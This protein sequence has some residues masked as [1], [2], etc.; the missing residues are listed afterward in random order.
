MNARDK[1]D[2][3]FIAIIHKEQLKAWKRASLRIFKLS[4]EDMTK[5]EIISKI[6]SEEYGKNII[7]MSDAMYSAGRL[8]YEAEVRK[9]QGLVRKETPDFKYNFKATDKEALDI[10]DRG[11]SLFISRYYDKQL[12]PQ[13]KDK[14]AELI[15]GQT[16]L[17]EVKESMAELLGWTGRKGLQSASNLVVTNDT[18]IRSVSATN[19]LEEVGRLK[20]KYF[21]TVD[22]VTSEICMALD[23]TEGE[24]ENAIQ[25][26]DDYLAIPREDY[27]AFMEKSKEISPFINYDKDT[28]SFYKQ[29]DNSGY[30]Q[31]WTEDNIQ[32][33]PGIALPPFHQYCRTEIHT[34]KD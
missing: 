33:I 26:R 10:L 4:F 16:G 6:M 13:L 32:D 28:N 29:G 15:S 23:G 21:V 3:H 25:L 22:E 14:M 7:P 11:N 20:Y 19:V 5:P 34:I 30:R 12:E 18:W 2:K 8:Q 1:I 31:T 27:T 24:V 17:K 9:M